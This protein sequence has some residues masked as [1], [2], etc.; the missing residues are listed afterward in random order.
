M[1]RF[2][3]ANCFAADM[4][5]IADAIGVSGRIDACVKVSLVAVLRLRKILLGGSHERF[6]ASQ[7]TVLDV[8]TWQ[9]S[10]IHRLRPGQSQRLRWVSEHELE[11]GTTRGGVHCA[12]VP[13]RNTLQEGVPVSAVLGAEAAQSFN[14]SAVESF[15]L[16]VRLGVIGRRERLFNPQD[17]ADIPKEC[18]GELSTSVGQHLR[19]LPVVVDPLGTERA[20]DLIGSH[21]SEGVNFRHFGKPIRYDEDVLVPCTGARKGAEQIDGHLFVRPRGREQFE[22][23]V[24]PPQPDALACTTR[25]IARDVVNVDGHGGPV[26]IATKSRVHA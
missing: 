16:P 1:E 10:V 2:P 24:V 22:I 11:R 17:F 15:G 5:H 3:N 6:K 12:V 19:G 8:L 18:R 9:V 25:A 4:D 14:Q 23:R 26:R 7:K 13:V 21:P 20:S